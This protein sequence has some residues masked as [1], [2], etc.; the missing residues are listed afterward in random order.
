M[1]KLKKRKLATSL[2]FKSIASAYFGKQWKFPSGDGQFKKELEN[3][4]EFRAIYFVH[5]TMKKELPYE[6]YLEEIEFM[7]KKIHAIEKSMAADI[8]GIENMMEEVY[9]V[10]DYL[11]DQISLCCNK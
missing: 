8:A 6:Q 9:M 1:R 11:D 5:K 2:E 3:N 10:C 4:P 7:Y